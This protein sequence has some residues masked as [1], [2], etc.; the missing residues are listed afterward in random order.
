M[1]E[2][3]NFLRRWLWEREGEAIIIRK[4]DLFWAG[5]GSGKYKYNIKQLELFITIGMMAWWWWCC[6][7]QGWTRRRW[8][9][10]TMMKLV[11]MTMLMTRTAMMMTMMLTTT[12]M[13]MQSQAATPASGWP[14]DR[15]KPHNHNFYSLPTTTNLI[16]IFIFV[17]CSSTFQ[18]FVPYLPQF[19]FQHH[20][21]PN[22]HFDFRSFFF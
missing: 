16:F 20:H 1:T 11:T 8:W 22:F 21:Q 9:R 6:W 2:V 17:R 12:A 18:Y 14:A 7:W 4:R 19:Q 10:W 13:M 15:K 5:E 3:I